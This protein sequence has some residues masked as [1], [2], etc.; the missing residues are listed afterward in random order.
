VIRVVVDANGKVESAEI[1]SDAGH[2]FGA[3]AIACALRTHFTPARAA[4][5]N[6]IRAQSPPIRVRFTR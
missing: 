2:G 1:V 3:A 5:G 6:P 4:D